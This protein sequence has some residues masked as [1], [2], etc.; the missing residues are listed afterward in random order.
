SGDVTLGGTLKITLT[1]GF[2]PAFGDSFALITA[3]GTVSGKFATVDVPKNAHGVPLFAV[4]YT[5]TGVVL[6]ATI[7]VNSTNDPGTGGATASET[8]LREAVALANTKA[9]LDFI[10]FDV[11]STGTITLTAPVLPALSGPVVID[12]TTQPGFAAGA[13]AIVLDG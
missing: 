3:G 1:N 12:A 13:P 7:I 10:Y 6:H 9:G 5:T 8:T 4:E 2:T 11:A